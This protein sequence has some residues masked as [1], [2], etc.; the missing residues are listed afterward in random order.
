MKKIEDLA[1]EK[2][3]SERSLPE[4]K[5]TPAENYIDWAVF[6]AREAQRWIPVE[7]ELPEDS[8]NL[9]QTEK[10]TYTENPVLVRTINGKCAVSK[11]SKFKGNENSKWEWMGSSSFS[12]SVTHWRPVERV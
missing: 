4:R 5:R 9:T 8:D 7:E 1:A 3:I 11:R 10:Y 2:Y 12:D 6:G